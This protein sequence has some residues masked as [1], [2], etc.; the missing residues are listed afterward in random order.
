MSKI[1]S[2]AANKYLLK[3]TEKSQDIFWIV[4]QNYESQIYVSPIFESIWGISCDELYADPSIWYKQVVPEDKAHINNL[5]AERKSTIDKNFEQTDIVY[6]IQTRDGVIRWIKDCCYVILNDKNDIIGLSGVAKDITAEVLKETDL[7]YAAKFF[8]QFAERSKSVF[9]VRDP[10]SSKQLYLSPAYETVWGRSRDSLYKNPDL[11]IETLV[12]T[13][14]QP[15]TAQTRSKTLENYGE[16]ANYE[17]TY[18]IKRPDG[19]IRW[20]KD[21]SFPIYDGKVC[22]GF[23]GIAEDITVDKL[24]EQELIEAKEKAEIANQVKSEFVATTSHELRTPLNAIMGMTQIL[25]KKSQDEETQQMLN[26]IMQSSSHL[27]GMITDILNFS[28]LEADKFELEKHSFSLKKC[29]QES[30][31]HLS[32]LLEHR[33]DIKLESTLAENLPDYIICD[34]KCVRQL[35]FNLIGNAIKFTDKGKITVTAKLLQQVN[36][37]VIIQIDVIDTGIGIPADKLE[38]IFERFTQLDSAYDRR[39]GGTGLGLAICK[40][41]INQL[42]GE[43]N[44]ESEEKKGSHFWITIPCQLATTE[45]I[46][47]TQI[48][49][50]HNWQNDI[51]GSTGSYSSLTYESVGNQKQTDKISSEIKE[52]LAKDAKSLS[53]HD[54]LIVVIEDEKINQIVLNKM[55]EVLGIKTI[56]F[57]NVKSALEYFNKTNQQVDIILTDIGLPDRDGKELIKELRQNKKYKQIPIIAITGY[58]ATDDIADIISSGANEVLNKPISNEV[59]ENMLDKYLNSDRL[60]T[61][62]NIKIHTIVN[63]LNASNGKTIFDYEKTLKQN[64]G[65]LETVKILVKTLQKELPIYKTLINTAIQEKDTITLSIQSHKLKGAVLAVVMPKLH[66]AVALLEKSVKNLGFNE[67]ISQFAKEL[68]E[69]IDKAEKILN[70]F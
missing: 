52:P 28:K 65:N 63:S 2:I 49:K 12:E 15:N 54:K 31:N 70:D 67:H 36:N 59:L 64:N 6:R 35:L 38:F 4:S 24:R 5:L 8:E 60:N 41:L 20:I 47:Q 68:L 57:A 46:K 30:L 48:I 14:K 13:D 55:L 33:S 44:V 23:A 1:D 39:Y 10:Q 69:E 18:R 22:I 11:W 51:P 19:E 26:A 40:H 16:S 42:G 32:H 29:I 62:S 61:E 45:Q 53:L 50:T 17:N 21:T 25:L 34:E 3:L 43:I 66:E 9:W 56:I 58:S 37:N 7:R 27:L